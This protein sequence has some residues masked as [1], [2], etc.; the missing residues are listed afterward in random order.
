MT[1]LYVSYKS[2]EHRAIL[3]NTRQLS[4]ACKLQAINLIHYV[5]RLKLY[6]DNNY[7]FWTLLNEFIPSCHLP[8]VRILFYSSPSFPAFT[9][10]NCVNKHICR[11]DQSFIL[12]KSFFGCTGHLNGSFVPDADWA[13][14]G[15]TQLLA[16]TVPLLS[17]WVCASQFCHIRTMVQLSADWLMIASSW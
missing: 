11:H 6:P 5:L 7:N 9:N 15:V 3:S 13:G 10:M 8:T 17:A 14:W 2:W 12:A 4:S 16:P 1:K